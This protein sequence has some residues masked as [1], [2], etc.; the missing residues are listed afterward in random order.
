MPAEAVTPNL[1][2]PGLAD[3]VAHERLVR[4]VSF[5]PVTESIAGFEVLP[6][7]VQHYVTL[8][9]ARSPLLYDLLPAPGELAQFL[10]TLSPDYHPGDAARRRFLRR[11]QSFIPRAAPLLPFR[12]C[13][14]RIQ[15]HN[16][17][18]LHRAAEV[19]DAARRYK[20]ETFQDRPARKQRGPAGASEP[21][22]FSDACWFCATL[23]REY[24]YRQAEVLGMPLKRVFQYIK[25]I[26]RHHNPKAPLFNPSDKV[27]GDY[28]EALEK[29]KGKP[30]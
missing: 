20:F 29:Q 2:V 11:C 23:G 8:S 7:T 28:L 26:R 13:R 17:R 6:M 15:K 10:W 19:I 16:E 24:G 27:K 30:S 14:A 9:V 5:L 12:W 22:Y 3:A 25:E 18:A 4:D 21:D 1:V